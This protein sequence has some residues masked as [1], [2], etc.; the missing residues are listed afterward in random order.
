MPFDDPL[1]RIE[2]ILDAIAKIQRYTLRLTFDTFDTSEL[3]VDAVVRNFITIGEAAGHVPPEI[4]ARY[5][6]IPWPEMRGLRNIVVHEY[7]R[8]DNSV[9]WRTATQHLPPLVP[10][11]R[12]ILEREP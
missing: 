6:A 10:L 9:I 7:T 8:V 5:P 11:L 12:D 2:D 1:G 4:V 3:T